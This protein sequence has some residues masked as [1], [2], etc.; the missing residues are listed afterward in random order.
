MTVSNFEMSWGKIS[1]LHNL[2]RDVHPK[3]ECT[4]EYSLKELPYL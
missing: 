1:D 4:I 2:L 3:K